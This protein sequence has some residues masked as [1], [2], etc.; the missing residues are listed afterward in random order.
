MAVVIHT[1]DSNLR[2]ICLFLHQYIECAI[3]N[4]TLILM[5]LTDIMGPEGQ[6]LK[7]KTP[8]ACN[9]IHSRKYL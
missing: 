6:E 4:A 7:Y 9:Y 5:N 2:P 3:I 1:N 8:L